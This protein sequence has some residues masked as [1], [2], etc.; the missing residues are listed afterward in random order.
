MLGMEGRR[1]GQGRVWTK[2]ERRRRER[3]RCK[4]K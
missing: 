4:C 2:M 3:E 1:E